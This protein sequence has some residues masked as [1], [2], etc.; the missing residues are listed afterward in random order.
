[1]QSQAKSVRR[2]LAELPV[3]RR[4]AIEAV[5]AVILKN[6]PVGY[7]ESVQSGM[8]GYCVPESRCPKTYAGAPLNFSAPASQKNHM[9]I[10]RMGCYGDGKL[11]RWCQ[12]ELRSCGK[13][14]DMVRS[15]VHFKKL[16]DL[17]LDLVGKA[18]A[19]MSADNFITLYEHS[20][21][22]RTRK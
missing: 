11:R 18:V 16:D 13:R 19:R 14:T 1:M 3:D 9:S 22:G 2:Y 5:R 20:R 17:P 7:E 10:G 4:R 6:P 12:A 15:C 8:I 21:V